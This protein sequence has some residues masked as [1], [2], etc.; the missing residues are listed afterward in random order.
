[1]PKSNFH[2]P[3]QLS[4][5][6]SQAEIP[7]SGLRPSAPPFAAFYPQYA[8]TYPVQFMPAAQWQPL[9]QQQGLAPL[10]P[11]PPRP[12]ALLP[13]QGG[14][15]FP[16][17]RQQ[18][19]HGGRQQQRGRH[20]R[21]YDPNR[22]QG[23]GQY[24]DMWQQVAQGQTW[25]GGMQQLPEQLTVE[26]LVAMVQRLPPGVSAIPTVAQGLHSL[27]SRA[28]AALL[29]DLSKNGLPHHALTI[30]DW[31]QSLPSENELSSLC[32]VFTYTT[33]ISLCGQR[34]ELGK[35]LTLVADMRGRGIAPNIHTYTA[36]INTCIRSGDFSLALDV[37]KTLE[38]E[39]CQPN[40]VTYNTLIDV[41]GK[42]GCWQEAVQVLDDM[43]AKR[44]QP[45]TRTYNTAIIA[46]NMCNQSAKALQVYERMQEQ[47]LEATATTY[48]ALVSA[49][50]KSD[51][52][53]AAL[54][55]Y[56]NM[57]AKRQERNIITYSSLIAAADR[58]GRWEEGLT[59]WD[60]MSGDRCHPNL[61]A[62]NSAISC[63][64]Q[65]QKWQQ[66]RDIFEQMKAARFKPD[67]STYTALLAAY[68]PA[69]KWRQALQALEQM[70][71]A[72]IRPDTAAYGAVIDLLWCSGIVGAQQRAQ[73]LFHLACRQSVRGMEAVHA[74]AQ[75]DSDT[76]EVCIAAPVPT[77]AALAL[78]KWL[79]DL[80]HAVQTNG[81]GSLR[82]RVVLVIGGWTH[83]TPAQTPSKAEAAPQV[84]PEEEQSSTSQAASQEEAVPSSGAGPSSPTPGRRAGRS[85]SPSRGQKRMASALPAVAATLFEGM[86]NASANQAAML[87]MVRGFGLPFSKSDDTDKFVLS[88]SAEDIAQ[89][90][91]APM[92]ETIM[93][94]F[95]QPLTSP[96]SGRSLARSPMQANLSFLQ[97]EERTATNCSA[98]WTSL[99]TFESYFPNVKVGAQLN[100]Q[101]LSSRP[102]CLTTAKQL[103]DS[104]GLSEAL[105]FDAILLLDRLLHHRSD[106]F[107][108]EV[109]PE[110]VGA[111]LVMA[112]RCGLDQ[113]QPV[114]DSE[115]LASLV[116]V[117]TGKF[118]HPAGDLIN[119]VKQLDGVC[120]SLTPTGS[121]LTT[122]SAVRCL[123]VYLERL[124][125]LQAESTSLQDT[126]NGA[127]ESGQFVSVQPSML[128]AVA[129]RVAR[130]RQ[131]TLPAWPT[132]LAD[133]TGWRGENTDSEFDKACLI[134]RAFVGIA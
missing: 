65:G 16:P 112:T 82:Q 115:A 101:Y 69:H 129:Y 18:G 111:S 102:Q 40:V 87:N 94:R 124:G 133:M 45:E 57:V 22:G 68:H 61:P 14:Q 41:Y 114:L 42:M 27:D 46:C 89:W 11:Q 120:R 117:P 24:R 95:A 13:P 80:R 31:L 23:Q 66:A 70:Q 108:Q 74:A 118:C 132:A 5:I 30:F 92:F 79:Q 93:S 21:Q 76:L 62:Y 71:A 96:L 72:S 52:L 85:R 49:Y 78:H 116:N 128:A 107:N 43:T 113:P 127:F 17:P 3:E 131:G 90:L 109:V 58:A 20:Q 1:M 25:Q 67:M 105:A 73:Q 9:P 60:H 81:P 54:E 51:D 29:K 44:V 12:R 83:S 119:F 36:L 39:G 91:Q 56:N 110:M 2:G 48:T 8:A 121:A 100:Q 64:A 104:L 103:A 53:D 10:L 123:N 84:S 38:D 4:N 50:C 125:A 88:A 59:I 55:V 77:V 19:R 98:A 63:C 130:E 37:F 26:D 106:L 15:P 97:A 75:D 28:C 32:D 122:V 7:L 35:A 86:D 6:I 134:M 33:V 47:E 126:I 34:Q 99:R